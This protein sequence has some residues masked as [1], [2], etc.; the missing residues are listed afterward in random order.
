MKSQIVRSFGRR[1]SG[2]WKKRSDVQLAEAPHQRTRHLPVVKRARRLDTGDQLLWQNNVTHVPAGLLKHLAALEL[3]TVLLLADPAQAV[4]DHVAALVVLADLLSVSGAPLVFN[5]ALGGAR[6]AAVGAVGRDD[7]VLSKALVVV[8]LDGVDVVAV[9]HDAVDGLGLQVID[10]GLVGLGCLLRVKSDGADDALGNVFVC[11]VDVDEDSVARR[12]HALLVLPALESLRQAPALGRVLQDDVGLLVSVGVVVAALRLLHL[13]LGLLVGPGTRPLRVLLVLGRTLHVMAVGVGIVVLT[14]I[15]SEVETRDEVSRNAVGG[16]VKS[17]GVGR[18]GK[19]S[20][21]GFIGEVAIDAIVLIGELVREELAS[22][23]DSR[24]VIEANI[25][26]ASGDH[27]REVGGIRC[28][29]RLFLD[30]GKRRVKHHV[31]IGS[32]NH[33]GHHVCEIE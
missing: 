23:S 25:I 19:N 1:P 17:S 27:V 29:G 12:Q 9:G 21:H 5:A 18:I 28:H 26:G 14:I 4:F 24:E 31:L 6:G 15:M 7:V 2:E 22:G 20:R 33:V 30:N 3:V 10:L 16:L 13:L 11:L 8:E 32:L